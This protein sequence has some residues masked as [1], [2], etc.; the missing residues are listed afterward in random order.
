ME[1]FRVGIEIELG[2]EVGAEDGVEEEFDD[3]EVEFLVAAKDK[4][5]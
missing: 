5:F 3:E 1:A 4:R 2:E